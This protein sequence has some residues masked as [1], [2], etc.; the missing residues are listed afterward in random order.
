MVLPPKQF[1]ALVAIVVITIIIRCVYLA[2][3]L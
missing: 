1:A 2:H 3:T